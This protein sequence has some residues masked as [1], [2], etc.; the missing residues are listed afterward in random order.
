MFDISKI[1]TVQP[2]SLNSG[3]NP[4]V[5]FCVWVLQVDGL[6]V[7]PFHHHL[8]GSQILQQVGLN[9][10]TWF[11]WLTQIVAAQDN[12]L[13]WHVP[14]IA[15]EVNSHLSRSIAVRQQYSSYL[16][17]SQ[18][19]MSVE[20]HSSGFPSVNM[21]AEQAQLEQYLYWQ[22]Q[23]YQEAKVLA[24]SF[25][26][27][28][29]PPFVW[30]GDPRVREQLTLLWQE[31]S[32]IPQH[33]SLFDNLDEIIDGLYQDLLQQFGTRLPTLKIYF[34]HYPEQIFLSVSPVT[35][36]ISQRKDILYEDFRQELF[37]AVECLVTS[38]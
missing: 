22:E 38:N 21:Q 13:L 26:A 17:Q 25:S 6:Q 8:N 15:A 35:I 34:V 23:Q 10:Q 27:E 4:N 16:N 28:T 29:S 1:S 24:G 2:W 32:S 5:G 30:E 33:I 11:A 20:S 9:A 18:P 14:D 3:F 31:Y 7:S 37:Q 36:L 19:E 12:R